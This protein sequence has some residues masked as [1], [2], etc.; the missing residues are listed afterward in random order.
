MKN[1]KGPERRGTE[2]RQNT[3]SFALT[4]KRRAAKDGGEKRVAKQV[5]S[6]GY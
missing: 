2:R 6:M 5:K 3:K 1:Y 4:G